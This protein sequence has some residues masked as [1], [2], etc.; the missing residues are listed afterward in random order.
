[1]SIS[2]LE[3][4]A[5][6]KRRYY[7]IY[8]LGIISL[9]I[10]FFIANAISFIPIISFHEPGWEQYDNSVENLGT[11]WTLFL[12]LGLIL[13]SYIALLLFIIFLILYIIDLVKRKGKINQKTG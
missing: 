4:R 10:G 3:K 13:F 9:L 2:N 12:N 1:M 8:I 11:L 5:R 7:V 6:F